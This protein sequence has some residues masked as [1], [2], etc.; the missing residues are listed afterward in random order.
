MPQNPTV[1]MTAARD[2]FIERLCD[3]DTGMLVT[4]GTD[5][6]LHARPMAVARCD[7]DGTL[8]FATSAQSGKAEE[9]RDCPDATATFQ[10]SGRF[11]TLSGRARLID[12]RALI[13]RL[14]SPA[15]RLW[16]PEG[17]TDPSLRVLELAGRRG[18]LW[19]R[20]GPNAVSFLWE[21]GKALLG[22]READEEEAGEHERIS[23]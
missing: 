4:R 3:F 16:F 9:I 11:V 19:D 14:W 22:G 2:R 23:L 8:L 13:E 6:G 21:A 20:S 15:W 10:E 5:G 7:D 18:E 17:P 12:D 1:P